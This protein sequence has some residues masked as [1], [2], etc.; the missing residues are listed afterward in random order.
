MDGV[1]VA[2]DVNADVVEARG[3]TEVCAEENRFDH[4]G[5][6]TLTSALMRLHGTQSLGR[7]YNATRPSRLTDAEPLPALNGVRERLP[8]KQSAT[9]T[10]SSGPTL[11]DPPP[12]YIE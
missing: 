6:G 7:T 11:D 3:E 1:G 9:L 10:Q 4:S 2:V 8:M 5:W 12:V